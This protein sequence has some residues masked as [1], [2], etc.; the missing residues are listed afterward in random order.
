MF[1]HDNGNLNVLAMEKCGHTAMWC[2]FDMPLMQKYFADWL[3]YTS[4]RVVVLRHPMERVHSAMRFADKLFNNG[5]KTK[6][7]MEAV[8]F[9]PE[10][11]DYYDNNPSEISE[12]V[13]NRHCRP[14]MH[15]LKNRD[16]RII[17]FEELPQYIP[18]VL[19]GGI[20][21]NTTDRN[22]DP[23]PSNRWFTRKDMIKEIEIYENLVENREVITIQEWKALT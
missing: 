20:A 8:R 5:Q 17:K 21:T 12:Y 9:T 7:I 1:V 6:E 23:F 14:Y 22:I 4:P 19:P 3:E 15:I 18:T 11:F 10:F 13:F 16:F 2:Y